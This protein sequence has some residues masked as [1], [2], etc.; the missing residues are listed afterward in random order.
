LP[1]CDALVA[2]EIEV[3]PGVP[4]AVA[5]V[6]YGFCSQHFVELAVYDDAIQRPNVVKQINPIGAAVLSVTSDFI[7]F[8]NSPAI[9]YGFDGSGL[10][11]YS[12][13]ITSQ[14]V[15]LPTVSNIPIGV[16]VREI[17]FS[18]NFLYA[19][20]GHVIDPVSGAI[21]GRFEGTSISGSVVR[22]DS[23]VGRTFFLPRSSS[24]CVTISLLGFD[25]N[26][27]HAVGSLAI[28]GLSCG[29]SFID[30]SSLIRWGANGLAFRTFSGEVV[31]LRTSLVPS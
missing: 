6:K 22:P 28:T 23:S 2:G 14:G 21:M 9:L 29:S 10:Q 15:G 7:E 17:K 27:F 8:S 3:L 24:G 25:Q 12:Y 26:A 4:N 20:T 30:T 18:G 16:I 11:L 31:I 1:G 13:S 5:V 19:D